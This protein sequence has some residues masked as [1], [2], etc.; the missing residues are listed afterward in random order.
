MNR[1]VIVATV[2]LAASLAT[3]ASAD[4]RSEERSQVK[5]EGPLGRIMSLL[6]GKATRDGI[7]TT[8]SVKGDRKMTTTDR[9]AQLVD[10]KEEKVYEIDL[11]S[12]TYRVVTFAE[13]RRRAEEEMRR[14]ADDLKKNTATDAPAPA[15]AER[16]QVDVEFSLQESGQNRII[17]GLDTH[18]VV[19]TVAIHEKGKTIEQGGLVL[20]SSA[21]L[22]PKVPG[23]TDVAA[24]DRRFAE[25]LAL[26]TMV[27]AQ[28][29]ARAM[30][31]YPM[32][33]DGM[34]RLQAENVKLDGTPM[35]TV[36]RIEAAGQPDQQTAAAKSEPAI[37]VATSKRG[38]GAALGARLAR[39]VLE[40]K[41]DGDASTPSAPGRATI[42]TI[43]HEVLKI[44]PAVTD[45]DVAIPA[46]FTLKS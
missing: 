33:A 2:L 18:E 9:T 36:V 7:V 35:L 28:Q 6:G 25:K 5:L 11:A 19:A 39:K 43:Q 40:K 4:V 30:A 41:D 26:P 16:P 37:P 3:V 27:D 17:S 45:A 8:V 15:T 46:G 10:L 21:W 38:F 13:L 34:K 20:T 29:L 12:K 1:P 23:A 22:A 42:M 32:L 24:F 31:M 14:A 44:T